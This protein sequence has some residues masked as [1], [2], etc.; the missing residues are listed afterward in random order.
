MVKKDI[1]C[2]KQTVQALTDERSL[3]FRFPE[4]AKEWHPTMN[5]ALTPQQVSY[6][7]KLKV[8]WLCPKCG[9]TY[10]C[11]ISNRTSK[12]RKGCPYCCHNPKASPKNNLAVKFPN[13]AKEWHPTENGKLTPAKVTPHSNKIC[14]WLCEKGHTYP[15]TVNNR[16]NGDGCP[17]CFGQRLSDNNRLSLVNPKLA[18]QWHP[19]KNNIAASEVS[20]GSNNNAWW[21][22]PVCSHEWKAKINNRSNG[23]GCPKCAKRKQ[24]SF[25]EQIIFYY[26][27]Q[28]FPDALN[29]YKFKGKE[30]DV[31]IPSLNMGIEYD[32]EYYHKTLQKYNRDK[33]KTEFLLS[34]GIELIRIREQKC[35]PMDNGLC[36]VYT[37]IQ[38][39]D[40]R[41]L[42]PVLSEILNYL[43]SV[44]KIKNTVIINISSIKNELLSSICAI[45]YKDSF[46]AFAEKNN[47]SLNSIW[48]IEKNKP[49]KPDMV[50]PYSD[51]Y[52][53][54]ICNKNPKHK[55]YA[56]VKSIS[57]GYGCDWCAN[58]HKYNS[59]EWIDK[60]I[61]I[62]GDKYDYSQ[63]NYV[64]S[65]TPVDIVCPIHGV[66]PQMPSEHLS[67]KGCKWCGGQGGFHELNTLA[68]CFPDLAKEWDYEHPDNKEL[69]P[70]DVV[71]TD[72]TNVY[73]WKCN[74]G[75]P[76]SYYAKISYRIKRKS[77]C[78]VCHGKQIAYD[79]SLE[80][81]RP[82][83]ASQWH[84]NNAIKPHEVSVGSEKSIL[85][86]CNNSD[87]RP[88][89][90]SVY[91]RV[92]LNSG[93]PECAGNI[94]TPLVYRKELKEKYPYIELLSEYEKSSIKVSC[95][96]T[97]CDYKWQPFPINV[98]RGKGCPKCKG[99]R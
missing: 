45:S 99:I 26:V 33:S 28:L 55:R 17:F 41:Y 78:A 73:W 76:H 12:G 94:K 75:K 71:V 88:Y 54:W 93:C 82:D 61:S 48:D 68:Y 7:K 59:E 83:L 10:P 89:K 38:T 86:E 21:I 19:T 31:Y 66:F 37:F 74:N 53:Y 25:P 13:I 16:S 27:N 6:G 18:T 34:N 1:R 67:G 40:Y 65:K 92:H 72:S 84:K 39:S 23:R 97:V 57:K 96:C 60:A 3:S 15:S 69:T 90:A 2:R 81:L 46:A 80:Y 36:K 70:N 47:D 43:C 64:N 49:L 9:E 62:H 58:R 42:V 95:R 52:F 50:K 98:L 29:G 5:G 11:L 22:C 87:H 35:Y 91:N 4:I 20:F 8:Y 51:M 44:N 24:S 56:P 14:K 85:W 63:I 30:I 77:G 32:G 79:T